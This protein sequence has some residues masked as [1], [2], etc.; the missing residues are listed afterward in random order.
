VLVV[1]LPMS[2]SLPKIFVENVGSDDLLE[3]SLAIFFAKE[4]Y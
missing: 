1:V 3:T 2:R 4:I